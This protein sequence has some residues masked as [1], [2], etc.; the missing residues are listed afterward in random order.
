[1]VLM[2]L[3]LIPSGLSCTGFGDGDGDGDGDP[4]M[5]VLLL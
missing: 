3:L 4:T 1:M 5:K 2:M